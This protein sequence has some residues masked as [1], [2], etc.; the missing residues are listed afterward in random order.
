MQ[1]KKNP[2]ALVATLL[3]LCSAISFAGEPSALWCDDHDCYMQ[4]GME[5][6]ATRNA[7]AARQQFVKARRKASNSEETRKENAKRMIDKA[8]DYYATIFSGQNN[9]DRLIGSR[10]Y[11]EAYQLALSTLSQAKLCAEI[12]VEISANFDAALIASLT[13]QSESINE[14]RTAAILE[15]IESGNGMMTERNY[16][17]AVSKFSFARGLCL[18]AEVSQYDV[19]N[20]LLEARYG[21][22]FIRGERLLDQSQCEQAHA[23]FSEARDIMNKNEALT[24]LDAAA[25]CAY[26]KLIMEGM[27]Q[28]EGGG[29]EQAANSFQ[30]A[31]SYKPDDTEAKNGIANARQCRAV[32]LL[33]QSESAFIGGNYELAAAHLD[34]A[35]EL[36][37]NAITSVSG[38]SISMLATE[39]FDGIVSKANA[40]VRAR[41]YELAKDL[42]AAAGEFKN[43]EE[44]KGKVALMEN[45]IAYVVSLQTAQDLQNNHAALRTTENL[46][47]LRDAWSAANTAATKG[48]VFG[49]IADNQLAKVNQAI[50]H[51]EKG[52]QLMLQYVQGGKTNSTLRQNAVEAYNKISFPC[53]LK[54]SNPATSG[55][56]ANEKMTV[57]ITYYG[58]SLTVHSNECT[59]LKGAVYIRMLAGNRSV[60][61][62]NLSEHKVNILNWL[63]SQT[64]DYPF[65]AVTRTPK[66]PTT[67]MKVVTFRVDKQAIQA[68]TARIEVDSRLIGCHKHIAIVSHKCGVDHGGVQTISLPRTSKVFSSAPKAPKS[69]GTHNLKNHFRIRVF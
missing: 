13:E 39:F 62:I 16:A 67:E 52:D 49:T 47:R 1:Y 12:K 35:R 26:E 11:L 37:P 3:L 54:T 5:S 59:R 29:C 41:S 65:R 55:A 28:L 63:S 43:K 53:A 61:P 22:A 66:I 14:D 45:K 51:A 33:G 30:K 42:F 64:S 4:Q 10:G 27:Q 19:D 56:S 6:L 2:V 21:E 9:I 38:K 50:S 58:P 32:T 68:G 15:A 34:D 46:R 36:D 40:E 48:E 7:E 17:T 60:Q 57:E 23:A 25:G 18:P 69:D 44:M 20:L 24:Q 8:K 31:L